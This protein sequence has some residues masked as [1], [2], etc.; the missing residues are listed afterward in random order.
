MR[1]LS[2]K[3]WAVLFAA[4]FCAPVLAN[5]GVMYTYSGNPFSTGSFSGAY[6]G[7]DN[8][9]GHFSVEGDLID[10]SSCQLTDAKYDLHI[11]FGD[12][13]NTYDSNEQILQFAVTAGDTGSITAWTISLSIPLILGPCDKGSSCDL[14]TDSVAGDVVSYLSEPSGR[15]TASPAMPDSS[16]SCRATGP[17]AKVSSDCVTSPAPEPG[18]L[19]LIL[20]AFVATWG[21]GVVGRSGWANRSRLIASHVQDL[22]P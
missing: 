18:S 10:C 15:A 8:V 20:I 4:I 2:T 17:A 19:P 7:T 9:S 14:R 6:T 1:V 5:A 3:Y 16:W 22:H 11:F 12:G 13:L 21:V